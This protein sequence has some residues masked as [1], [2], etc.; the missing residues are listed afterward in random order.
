MKRSIINIKYYALD[1][2]CYIL[3]VYN[4]QNFINLNTFKFCSCTINLNVKCIINS[5]YIAL[6]SKVMYNAR[7]QKLIY[8]FI[9]IYFIYWLGHIIYLFNFLK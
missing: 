3:N 4:F 7:R 8:P 6:N 9:K 2:K 1:A 5:V